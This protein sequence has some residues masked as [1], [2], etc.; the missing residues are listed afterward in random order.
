M[1]EKCAEREREERDAA[2]RKHFA[3]ES[4]LRKAAE[5]APTVEWTPEAAR[6]GGARLYAYYRSLRYS[7]SPFVPYAFW[8]RSTHPCGKDKWNYRLRENAVQ[9]FC[10]FLS[11]DKAQNTRN[12]ED[13][14]AGCKPVGGKLR[15]ETI[16]WSISCDFP[17]EKDDPVAYSRISMLVSANLNPAYLLR[18]WDGDK[19]AEKVIP[20]GPK[21]GAVKSLFDDTCAVIV[22]NDV[23][24]RGDSRE[25]ADLCAHL[26]LCIQGS[27]GA[28]LL[29][30]SRLCRAKGI[31]VGGVRF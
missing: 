23:D 7:D 22:F 11:A 6:K 30:H 17:V 9:A 26:P 24:G 2:E 8:P 28:R 10:C 27:V 3:E 19:D 12:F 1:L 16:Q 31:R 29:D 4:A 25:G 5:L 20:L 21:S 13:M 15:P 14:A 18:E